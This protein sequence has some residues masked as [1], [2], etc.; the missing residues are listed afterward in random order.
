MDGVGCGDQDVADV[1][2]TRAA[3]ETRDVRLIPN[4]PVMDGSFVAVHY[5]GAEVGP[6]G[7]VGGRTI[8][9]PAAGCPSGRISE[10]GI[11]TE[12]AVVGFRDHGILIRPV[13][14]ALGRGFDFPP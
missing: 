5:G 8:R 10:P 9:L 3:P 12:P 13:V 14:G 2:L 7:G 1:L 4:P 6:V 11:N